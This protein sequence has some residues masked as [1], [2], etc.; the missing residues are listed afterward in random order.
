MPE[1][2]ESLDQFEKNELSKVGLTVATMLSNTD[3]LPALT[4]EGMSNMFER[5]DRASELT[6]AIAALGPAPTP[7]ET[8]SPPE[9]PK[10]ANK[11]IDLEVPVSDADLPLE[12]AGAEDSANTA[13]ASLTAA[14]E[15]LPVPSKT[16]GVHVKSMPAVNSFETSVISGLV[17]PRTNPLGT[18]MQSSQLPTDA[19]KF[20]RMLFRILNQFSPAYSIQP[21]T[22]APSWNASQ[23]GFNLLNDN[24]RFSYERMPS[25]A[26]A[27]DRANHQNV[28][29]YYEDLQIGLPAN[30]ASMLSL[31]SAG[32]TELHV[33]EQRAC[34]PEYLRL[35][36]VGLKVYHF[37]LQDVDAL[38]NP[39]E[40]PEL[41]FTAR[42]FQ[43]LR[44]RRAMDRD[45]PRELQGRKYPRF[46]FN[47]QRA[48]IDVL[49]DGY[50]NSVSC[51]MAEE[52]LTA[53]N[54]YASSLVTTGNQIGFSK[55]AT[56]QNTADLARLN[57][58]G[59]KTFATNYVKYLAG[60]S[61]RADLVVPHDDVD[62]MGKDMRALA[63]YALLCVV[64][65]DLFDRATGRAILSFILAPFYVQLSTVDG[66]N[67][68]VAG[69]DEV[70]E[71][72]FR[73]GNNRVLPPLSAPFQGRRFD[74]RERE[75][76]RL[77]LQVALFGLLGANPM[78]GRNLNV[79]NVAMPIDQLK[80]PTYCP[81]SIAGQ[82][83]ARNLIFGDAPV[84]TPLTMHNMAV[85]L[86]SLAEFNDILNMREREGIHFSDQDDPAKIGAVTSLAMYS[87][88]V[89]AALDVRCRPGPMI[90]PND[91]EYSHTLELTATG[92][93]SYLL[94]GVS[95]TDISN[96]YMKFTKLSSLML[97]GDSHF[98]I[99][100]L[101]AIT[102]Y[103]YTKCG[104]YANREYQYTKE[105]LIAQAAI[106][107]FS[108]YYTPTT[109]ERNLIEAMFRL[110]SSYF[111]S[112]AF[113]NL[114]TLQG[115]A[116]A[117]VEIHLA[118][119]N[120][121][122]FYPKT[123]P[124]DIFRAGYAQ[125]LNPATLPDAIDNHGAVLKNNFGTSLALAN[126]SQLAANV[127][128]SNGF[129]IRPADFDFSSVLAGVSQFEAI[130]L[131]LARRVRT[132]YISGDVVHTSWVTM[133]NIHHEV[134]AL[135]VLPAKPLDV[136]V[137]ALKDLLLASYFNFDVD[138]TVDIIRR[139]LGLY[140]S[141]NNLALRWVSVDTANGQFDLQSITGQE[142][143]T[144]H[145][146]DTNLVIEKKKYHDDERFF[147]KG[148][149][150]VLI[151]ELKN[152]GDIAI[153]ANGNG[154]IGPKA[155]PVNH[156]VTAFIT[157]DDIRQHLIGVPLIADNDF[158]QVDLATTGGFSLLGCN[159]VRY[160]QPALVVTRQLEEY[161]VS[162]EVSERLPA[163]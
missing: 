42:Y 62:G 49:F 76:I 2:D 110:R 131:A 53:A 73:I 47:G 97:P 63:Y 24:Q 72:Y 17:F 132:V 155:I 115:R 71:D 32:E 35:L 56:T 59:A 103:I 150:S 133:T 70:V 29:V 46:S 98:R 68:P 109:T 119:P 134:V 65:I 84:G 99:Y 106:S 61:R 1:K 152:N 128:N 83:G 37:F 19:T 108:T 26:V 88:L 86:N 52:S 48:L 87:V 40:N 18:V 116:N 162:Q 144:L 41:R 12:D 113:Q 23:P 120:T 141:Q 153:D 160:T 129:E 55:R 154:S 79:L 14:A 15:P 124:S 21:L 38:G 145:F 151:K 7:E 100:V 54:T 75:T 28:A 114:F 92:A 123:L 13:V 89:R 44:D 51:I 102:Q 77:R 80:D 36:R 112:N 31:G 157:I 146:S 16:S 85:P 156:H 130:E 104:Q 142:T 139:L 39:L 4:S 158:L 74:N 58:T 43:Y 143:D 27:T 78:Q 163:L 33:C 6:N 67:R 34:T 127:A 60:G 10:S 148:P 9:P 69:L 66:N 11:P 159:G 90:R 25:S 149:L 50:N 8:A 45:T 107:A 93:L 20:E 81:Y 91:L 117:L 57:P 136:D 5:A 111:R 101:C 82:G 94:Y 3:F 140:N 126:S 125:G 135:A 22:Q 96:D 118:M 121:A 137:I 138:L 64:P 147:L 161:T 95:H 105:P 122:N 30:T